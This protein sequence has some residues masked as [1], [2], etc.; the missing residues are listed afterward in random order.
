MTTDLTH[1]NPMAHAMLPKDDIGLLTVQRL[2]KELAELSAA[3]PSTQQSSATISSNTALGKLGALPGAGRRTDAA[4]GHLKQMIA[5]QHSL[6]KEMKLELNRP[7][8]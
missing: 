7:L 5:K 1:L 3:L 8:I 4:S 6:L 2:K